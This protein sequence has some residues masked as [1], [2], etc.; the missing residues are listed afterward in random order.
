[1]NYYDDPT[2]SNSGL[3]EL[4]P[5]EGGS[6]FRFKKWLEDRQEEKELSY[7]ERGRMLHMAA[8]EPDLYQVADV[9]RPTGLLGETA[10]RLVEM[11]EFTDDAI[12]E[13]ANIVQYGKGWNP[14]TIVRKVREGCSEYVAFMKEAEGKIVL[15]RDTRETIDRCYLSLQAHPWARKLLFQQEGALDEYAIFAKLQSSAGTFVSA[16]GKIDRLVQAE[17]GVMHNID[18][19]TTSKPLHKFSSS[20]VYYR[21]YRQ[22]A[23]YEDL[24]KRHFPDTRQVLHSLV[25]V[26]TSEPF[27]VCVFTITPD[28][29]EY[30]RKEY[31][32]LLTIYDHCRKTGEWGMI[33]SRQMKF[34][35]GI[36]TPQAVLDDSYIKE[37]EYALQASKD[38]EDLLDDW[39][40]SSA[41]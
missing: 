16:K 7:L 25:V 22:E 40:D 13:A 33:H 39:G 27:E 3:S 32:R 6:P 38:Q 2:I 18:I 30:G 10:I 31:Q 19:K 21:Y 20:Y 24:I 14:D 4:N 36:T 28:W 11:G 34:V 17:E 1:M 26:E 12:L 35:E 23:V 29:I 15:T 41:L 37:M 5:E 9:D 8:L